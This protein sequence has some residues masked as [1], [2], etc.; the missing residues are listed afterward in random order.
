MYRR[1]LITTA[2][3]SSLALA[4]CL[5]RRPSR[6]LGDIDCTS[7]TTDGSGSEAPQPK[8][9]S[10]SWHSFQYDLGNTGFNPD[11]DGPSDCPDLLWRFRVD[12][13]EPATEVNYS[14]LSGPIVHDG[15]VYTRD[16]EGTLY[17][18]D[19][20]SGSIEWTFDIPRWDIY[21]PTYDDSTLYVTAQQYLV[22][23]DSESRRERWTLTPSVLEP[24]PMGD[25][26][27]WMY[28]E[29][30][31]RDGRVFVGT[32]DNTFCAIDTATRTPLWQVDLPRLASSPI[33][34]SSD[35]YIRGQPVIH[36][37]V[38][39][40]ALSA[41]YLFVLDVDTG[42]V[43]WT[44]EVSGSIV[45]APSIRDETVYVVG[46]D[47]IQALSLTDGAVKWTYGNDD[48]VSCSPAITD[49]V[50]VGVAG[51]SFGNRMLVGIDARTGARR[52]KLPAA[53][54]LL[55]APSVAGETVVMGLTNGLL[56]VDLATGDQR[57]QAQTNNI[58]GSPALVNDMV[59]AGDSD[60]YVYAVR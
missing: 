18:L 23:I 38:V 14:I 3:L 42:G 20:T 48:H 6:S 39:A 28:A 22:A 16:N 31:A 54:E 58:L 12:P 55:A 40:V 32:I 47:G 13:N 49:D 51:S 34:E 56:A 46:F 1:E 4:G 53:T 29:V 50:V 59:I 27:E 35:V 24:H 25:D 26:R 9:V 52:W 11:A 7:E 21:G 5:S 37:D 33:E 60:G 57:W 45:A 2:G 41:G 19:A 30:A 44:H 17:A 15:V 8:S 10:G 43:V 36:D